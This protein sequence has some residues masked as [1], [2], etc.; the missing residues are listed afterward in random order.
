VCLFAT[1]CA[2]Q[3]EKKLD[4][5][6]SILGALLCAP[7]ALTFPTLVHL[8]QLAKTKTEKIVDI[9]LVILSVAV[10]VLSTY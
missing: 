6:L 10:L 5:F 3:L 8:K 1:Y 4:V 2:V 7:L 9:F